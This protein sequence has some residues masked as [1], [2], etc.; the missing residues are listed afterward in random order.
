MGKRTGTSST[1]AAKKAKLNPALSSVADAVKKSSHLPERCR[2]MLIDMIPFSLALPADM[3]LESHSQVVGMLEETLHTTKTDMEAGAS[4]KNTELENLKSIMADSE[5][6]VNQADAALSAQ[7][8]TADSAKASLDEAIAATSA[9]EKALADQKTQ[10]AAADAKLTS[11]KEEKA[12]L[13][14]VLNEH[15]KIPMEAL[16]APHY[17]ELEPFIEG[18][19]LDT[20][21]LTTLPGACTKSKEE[22][23]NFDHV[24]LQELEKAFAVK[25]AG[26]EEIVAAETPASAEREAAVKEAE[27]QVAA[28]KAA[29]TELEAKLEDAQKLQS[30]R[31]VALAQ[32]KEA[33]S[34]LKLQVEVHTGQWEKAHTTLK[35]FENGAFANFAT[36]KAKMTETVEAAPAGA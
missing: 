1:A 20:S 27:A 25:I 6:A 19:Q 7:R 36:Y 30:D 14:S 8:E 16:E 31:E 24:V 12:A 21:L 13:E 2:A 5:G 32:A 9:C 23:G 18:L 17:A 34:D 22:R 4:N 29:Q 3:R 35:V 28:K 15:F 33:L 10:Q 26:L 11:T